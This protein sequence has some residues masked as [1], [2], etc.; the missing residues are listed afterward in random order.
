MDTRIAEHQATVLQGATTLSAK[1]L[2]TL[3]E[4]EVSGDGQPPPGP[5][6][7]TAGGGAT[8]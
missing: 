1:E 6:D 3:E 7:D 8:S 5:D 4:I 2:E